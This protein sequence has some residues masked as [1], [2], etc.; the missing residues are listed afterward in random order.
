[1]ITRF[2]K[3]LYRNKEIVYVGVTTRPINERFREH[4]LSK[5]LN[6]ELY[7]VIEFDRIMH[8]EINSLEVYYEEHKKVALLEQKYIKEELEKGSHL[9]NITD[10]GE[11]GNQI[12]NKVRREEF[13]KQ[14]G[15]YDGYKKYQKIRKRPYEWLFRWVIN[16]SMNNV[17]QWLKSWIYCKGT[18]KS[19]IWLNTWVR[20]RTLNKPKYWLQNWI[21]IKGE[22]K[23]RRWLHNWITNRGISKTRR[24]CHKW[25]YG[26]SINKLKQWLK[27]W[28]LGKS[29]SKTKLWLKYWVKHRSTSKTKIWLFNWRTNR[30]TNKVKRWLYNWRV[31]TS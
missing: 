22:Y 15:S 29:M 3:I 11:W 25:I 16:R 30:S 2:Y 24:W 28:K 18:P 27:N 5:G 21:K 7:T 8:P 17:K 13:L 23:L 20:C 1:M 19:R 4:I 9:L 10:G 26:R 14:F 12:L 6:P 31:N